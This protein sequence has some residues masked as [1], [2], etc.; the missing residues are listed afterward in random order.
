[1]QWQS[2]SEFIAMG[3]RGF[4]VW[5]SYGVSFLLIAAELW[6]LHQRRKQSLQRLC[7]LQQIEKD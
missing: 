6:L 2:F 5:G 3:G 1:M 7:Q 4:F